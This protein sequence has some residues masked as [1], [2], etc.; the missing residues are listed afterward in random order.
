MHRSCDLHVGIKP[1]A[2]TPDNEYSHFVFSGKFSLCVRVMKNKVNILWNM[3]LY[4]YLINDFLLLMWSH[5]QSVATG[6][7][8]VVICHISS[9]DM[10]SKAGESILIPLRTDLTKRLLPAA[11]PSIRFNLDER[12]VIERTC[13]MYWYPS[14][15]SYNFGSIQQLLPL[16]WSKLMQRGHKSCNVMAFSLKAGSKLLGVWQIF[17]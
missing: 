15:S 17:P 5:C 11:Y 3:S 4:L 14:A 8:R 16:K 6:S 2:A 12:P 13:K 9:K 10:Y 1:G 7:H